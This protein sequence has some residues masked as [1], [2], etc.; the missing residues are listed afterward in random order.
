MPLL[1]GKCFTSSV[2]SPL[3]SKR[4]GWGFRRGRL[5]DF[6]VYPELGSSLL[7]NIGKEER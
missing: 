7:I 5:Q 6:I 1:A 4:A 2:P 3:E